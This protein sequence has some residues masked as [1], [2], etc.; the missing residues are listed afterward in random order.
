MSETLIAFGELNGGA[1]IILVLLAGC[2]L[3]VVGI[4]ISQAYR[5]IMVTARGWPP[6]HLDADGDWKPEPNVEEPPT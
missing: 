5:C 1:Q 2:G 3:R 6:P 4:C